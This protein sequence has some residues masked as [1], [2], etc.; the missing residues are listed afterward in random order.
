[1]ETVILRVED[2]TDVEVDSVGEG[3]VKIILHLS[4]GNP[5]TGEAG[6]Q[7][8]LAPALMSWIGEEVTASS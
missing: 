2:V 5:V 8:I 6:D 7:L 3:S 4:T 1:M